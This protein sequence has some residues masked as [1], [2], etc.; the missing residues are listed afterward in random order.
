[1][2]LQTIAF[3][4]V[5]ASCIFL[6]DQAPPQLIS[7]ISLKDVYTMMIL[8]QNISTYLKGGYVCNLYLASHICVCKAH[9]FL[10][11]KYII[12]TMIFRKYNDSR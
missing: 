6:I 4:S 11:T 2:Q 9:I 8:K 1:M 12:I 5:I 10:C 3:V 7:C